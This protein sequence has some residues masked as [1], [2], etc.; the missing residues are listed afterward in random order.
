[1]KSKNA[2]GMQ[3][4]KK[5]RNKVNKIKKYAIGNYHMYNNLAFDL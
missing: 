3:I 1:M 2:L 4:L 5:L